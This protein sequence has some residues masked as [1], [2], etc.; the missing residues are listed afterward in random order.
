MWPYHNWTVLFK[1]SIIILMSSCRSSYVM[2]VLYCIHLRINISLHWL[3]RFYPHLVFKLHFFIL[4]IQ[5]SQKQQEGARK[6]AYL[7]QVK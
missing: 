2:L 1:V 6:S 4:R 3:S 7:R 5:Q